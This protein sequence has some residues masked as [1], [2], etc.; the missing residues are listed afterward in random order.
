MK[1]LWGVAILF[2]LHL[3]SYGNQ[4]CEQT[5]F[6]TSVNLLVGSLIKPLEFLTSDSKAAHFCEP[7]KVG[8]TF[9]EASKGK[10]LTGDTPERRRLQEVTGKF[11][12][13]LQNGYKN[14]STATLI[15]TEQ[16][17]SQNILLLTGHSVLQFKYKEGTKPLFCRD[18]HKCIPVH[19]NQKEI[20][21][22][23]KKNLIVN[24]FTSKSQYPNQDY[25]ILTLKQPLSKTPITLTKFSRE[26]ALLPKQILL[27]GYPQLKENL[28]IVHNCKIKNFRKFNNEPGKII[29]HNCPT[30]PGSSGGL[31][32]EKNRRL[33]PIAVHFAGQG[34]TKTFDDSYME[35]AYNASMPLDIII[36]KVNEHC[37]YLKQLK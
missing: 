13:Q 5:W 11:V 8:C 30:K 16:C 31:I 15:Q 6:E 34:S 36:D 3:P 33:S 26:E 22:S 7:D 24:P 29:T 25:A 4:P 32:Y 21:A 1:W 14:E 18:S 10:V 28:H 9:E 35:G 20:E 17:K 37:S 23:L 27:T 12:F 19:L 2:F